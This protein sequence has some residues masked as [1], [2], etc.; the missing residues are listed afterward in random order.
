MRME[1]RPRQRAF[2]GVDAAYRLASALFD[3]GLWVLVVVFLYTSETRGPGWFFAALA[4][5][6]FL[7]AKWTFATW[8]ILAWWRERRWLRLNALAQAQGEHSTAPYRST[9]P[10]ARPRAR[11]W[12]R[13]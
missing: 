4:L 12:R 10:P 8:S 9:P 1:E 13:R 2:D 7:L 6:L 3:T 11:W 5:G